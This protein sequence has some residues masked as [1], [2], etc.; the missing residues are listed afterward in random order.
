[1]LQQAKAAFRKAK[2][3][4][5]ACSRNGAAKPARSQNGW[6]FLLKDADLLEKP[7]LLMVQ[8]SRAHSK[9]AN[10][11]KIDRHLY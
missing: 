1:M 11:K 8:K 6:L 5:P 7:L 2:V 3:V 4:E 9:K 10:F